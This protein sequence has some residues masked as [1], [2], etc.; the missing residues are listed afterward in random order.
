MPPHYVKPYVKRNKNDAADAAAICE[1]VTRPTMRFVLV[2]TTEQQSI[3]MLHRTNELLTRQRTTLINAI[4]AHM[5]EFGIVAPT[6]VPQVR[7]L[8]RVIADTDDTRLPP[9]ARSCLESL[10][11]PIASRRDRRGEKENPCLALLQRGQLPPGD[12]PRPRAGLVQ[13]YGGFR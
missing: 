12:H 10:A 11:A 13:C 9:V 5:A 7:K 4:R 3:L 2:K 6:G 8:F 1:A